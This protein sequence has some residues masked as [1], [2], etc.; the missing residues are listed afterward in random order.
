MTSA[1]GRPGAAS[2]CYSARVERELVRAGLKE[3]RFL[4]RV[5]KKTLIQTLFMAKGA[6]KGSRKTFADEGEARREF[7]KAV[8][9]K[10]RVGW[11]FRPPRDEWK[12][13]SVVF[14][15]FAPGGGGG[16]VLDL[17]PDGAQVLTAHVGAGARGY[18]INV[19]D[20]RS[21]AWRPLVKAASSSQTFV[22]TALFDRRGGVYFSLNEDTFHV[23]ADGKGKRKVAGY[24]EFSSAQFNPFVL[25]PHIDQSRRRLVVFDEKSRVKVLDVDDGERVVFEVSTHHAT[26]ECRG[27]GLSPS[28]KLLALYRPSRGVVYQ[29]DDALHDTSNVVEVYDVDRGALKARLPFAQKIDHVGLAPDDGSLV[30]TWEYAQG[31]VGVGFD[32]TPLWQFD[33][34]SRADRLDTAY[35]WA[36]SPDGSLLAVGRGRPELYDARTRSPV[37][38]AGRHGYRTQRL[39]FS[40]DGGLLAASTDATC[41]LY[42]L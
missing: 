42:A 25:Q 24:R 17:S 32:G 10:M 21:G 8:R 7:D 33:D 15:C 5:E 39:V 18:E 36:F 14:E 37:K 12:V 29:H 9:K 27:A 23:N 22:H 28:G 13:G 34:D 41:V 6:T 2:P 35:T 3:K 11:V 26:T 1:P 4:V 20:V 31:P 19:V 40:D 16:A 30:L 38:L